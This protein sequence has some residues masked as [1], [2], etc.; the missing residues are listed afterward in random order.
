MADKKAQKALYDNL[1]KSIGLGDD[2]SVLGLSERCNFLKYR[3]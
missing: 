1:Q 2:E 3:A